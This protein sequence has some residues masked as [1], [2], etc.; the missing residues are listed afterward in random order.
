MTATITTVAPRFDVAEVDALFNVL[1]A[2]DTA[3]RGGIQSRFS[4]PAQKL[5]STSSVFALVTKFREQFAGQK[6]AS[7]AAPVERSFDHAVGALSAIAP[8]LDW[9]DGAQIMHAIMGETVTPEAVNYGEIADRFIAK[10]TFTKTRDAI[11]DLMERFPGGDPRFNRQ[12]PHLMRHR[13]HANLEGEPI[14]GFVRIPAGTFTM[15]RSEEGDNK[16]RPVMIN[17]PF[18]IAR[19]LTTVAQYARFVG[20]GGY[21]AGDEYWDTQGITWRTGDFT[22]E[23][24]EKAYQDW[25]ARRPAPLRLQPVEWAAQLA[26]PSRPVT[27]VCWFE[28]R[29]YARWLDEQL[30]Q[31]PAPEWSPLLEKGYGAALP[32]EA[33]WER[34]ARAASL[35]ASHAHRW[36]WGDGE[37][38]AK[39]MANIEAS[40]IGHPSCVGVFPPNSIGLYD[41]AGNVWQWM[42]NVYDASAT[43][44]FPNVRKDR[45]LKTDTN[46]DKCEHPSLRGGSWIYRPEHASCSYRG[47]YPPGR[48]DDYVGFRVMLSLAKK[49]SVTPE[50]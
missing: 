16:P 39:D 8:W 42:D 45:V 11:G 32:T 2:T 47:R 46:V 17:A 27:G 30:A 43:D 12:A 20:A 4:L 40:G 1:V 22:S 7:G 18:Y 23:V 3:A 35:T 13:F 44:I 14:P 19:T 5:L 41:M 6:D 49:R 10:S 31:S 29:A 9:A 25:L 33:Q 37:S 36:P 21:R 50:P 48:W 24:E 15:G 34:A 28:A 38:Q 26:H